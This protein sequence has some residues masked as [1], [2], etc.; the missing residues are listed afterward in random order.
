MLLEWVISNEGDRGFTV[1]LFCPKEPEGMRVTV[2]FN[3]AGKIGKFLLKKVFERHWFFG[4]CGAAID[5]F[6]PRSRKRLQ[7]T[8]ILVFS[9]FSISRETCSA[10]NQSSKYF[11]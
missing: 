3:L 10:D 2:A 7:E 8:F 1:L 6:F 5:S 4:N 9:F 11:F